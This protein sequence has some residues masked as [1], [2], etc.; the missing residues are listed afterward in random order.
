MEG[1]CIWEALA[2]ISSQRISS[3]TYQAEE[4]SI[5]KQLGMNLDILHVIYIINIIVKQKF[6]ISGSRRIEFF[7]YLVI[8]VKK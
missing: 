4:R 7:Y 8:D 2:Y 3:Q 1:N 6:S 5:K